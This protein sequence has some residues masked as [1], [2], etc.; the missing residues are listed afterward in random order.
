MAGELPYRKSESGANSIEAASTTASGSGVTGHG[1]KKYGVE[2]YDSKEGEATLHAAGGEG[3]ID[4]EKAQDVKTPR[5]VVDGEVVHGEGAVKRTLKQRHMAMIALGGSIGTGLFIGAGAALNTGGPVGVW[6][7]YILMA[8]IVYAMMVALG[9]MS[10]L[11]PVSGGFTHFAARFV[12][13]ALGFAT[14]LNYFYSWA[15]TIPVEIVAAQIVIAYW[16]AT[17]NAAVYMTVCLVLILAVNFL[18]ARAYGETEFWFSTMKILAIVGL[19]I[20][21]VVLMCGGGP[22]H[23]AIGFRYW[24][25]PGPFNQM[26]LDKGDGYVPGRWGQFLAFFACLVQAAFSFLGTEIIATTLGEAENPRKTVPRAIKRVFYRLVVFYVFGIFIISVLVP[27]DNERLINGGGDASASPFV[28]AI[29]NAGINAL[30]SIVN[31]VILISAWSAGNSDVYAASRVLYALALEGQVPRIFR[32]CTKQGLP[33]YC[34]LV[35]SAFGF[36]CYMSTGG[37]SAVQAFDWLYNISS[38]AG[39]LTWWTILL[40]YIR[41]YHGLKVQG[42][43]RDSFPYKAP[44]QPYLSYYGLFWFTVITL[45]N[46]FPVFL[47]GNWDTSKFI[48]AYITLPIFVGCYAGWK[49]FKKTKFVSLAEMDFV[50]GMRELDEMQERDEVKFQPET[51]W[52]K[53]MSYMF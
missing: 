12:D 20:L 28:I 4:A 44:L 34:I 46:G 49:F 3:Y 1:E 43:S 39:I 17:T 14:G 10:A 40:S 18:G 6:L 52:G 51:R 38:I 53:F 47:Q 41:M 42:I 11:F 19:I 50:T 35:T 45:L 25:S 36:L 31:A 13:P 30:P 9:E 23:D 27:Y 32:R 24:V 5:L 8:T 2:G 48:A 15:I 21:G 26:T 16:D 37:D 33:I 22:N 7:G 29:K